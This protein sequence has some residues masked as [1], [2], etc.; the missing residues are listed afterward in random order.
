MKCDNRTTPFLC[1]EVEYTPYKSPL[2]IK[3]ANFK[4]EG[5]HTFDYSEDNITYHRQ[6]NNR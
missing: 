6:L 1:D 5:T 4:G 2:M 3:L